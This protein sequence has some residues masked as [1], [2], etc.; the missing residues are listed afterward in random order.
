MVFMDHKN[1]I[2]PICLET[3]YHK[4]SST[5]GYTVELC[6]VCESDGT[7]G[8]FIW[9]CWVQFLETEVDKKVIIL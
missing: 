1:I 6:M 3:L 8:D 9:K 7:G 4:T 5:L 2:L